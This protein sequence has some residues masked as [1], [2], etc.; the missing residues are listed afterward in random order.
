[1]ISTDDGALQQEPEG[2]ADHRDGRDERIAP[3]VLLEHEPLGQALGP[4]RVDVIELQFLHERRPHHPRDD[5]GRAVAQRDR[6]QDQVPDRVPEGHEVAGQERVDR[7]EAGARGDERDDLGSCSCRWAIQPSCA[8]NM[9]RRSDGEPEVRHARPAHRDDARDVV[10]RPVAPRPGV[11]A[12][13]D[14]QHDGHDAGGDGQLERR[15]ELDGKTSATGATET[16]GPA[17]VALQHALRPVE[18]LDGQRLIE[19]EAR[20]DLSHFLGRHLVRQVDP[21]GR[22]A[23]PRQREDDH[24]HA[25]DEERQDQKPPDDVVA[26]LHARPPSGS[27]C[28]SRRDRSQGLA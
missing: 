16:P 24:R 18:V 6:G 26:E 3:G 27:C 21:D 14:A 28:G 13:P 1:M 8:Q 2:Q 7:V 9:M 20:L 12:E 5:R 25:D 4:R 22:P 17:E 11:G 23:D 15:G 19:V 10:G